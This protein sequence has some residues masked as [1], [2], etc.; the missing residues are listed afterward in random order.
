MNFYL[1]KSVIAFENGFSD[2]RNLSVE[3]L[4]EFEQRMFCGYE[5]GRVIG[6]NIKFLNHVSDLQI[7]DSHPV[8][9]LVLQF[10]SS[11]GYKVNQVSLWSDCTSRSF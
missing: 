10:T 1:S 5:K 11:E 8:S 3:R 4:L 2:I 9:T 6:S 7:E